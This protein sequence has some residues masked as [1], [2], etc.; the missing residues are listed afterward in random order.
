MWSTVIASYIIDDINE[1]GYLTST[2]EDLNGFIQEN[3]TNLST[4]IADIENVLSV[5]QLLNKKS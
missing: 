4:T 3:E 2:L 5:V 1:E